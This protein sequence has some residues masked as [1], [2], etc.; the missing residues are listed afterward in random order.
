MKIKIHELE[1][2]LMHL[3]RAAEPY[4]RK[5]A[6]LINGLTGIGKT[7]TVERVAKK[8]DLNLI[9]IRL[10]TESPENIGGLPKV[11]NDY[12]IKVLH[13]KFKIMTLP[14]EPT[15]EEYRK[16]KP[17]LIFFDEA[18]RSSVWV[19]N[20]IMSLIYE[21][22]I[23]NRKLHPKS[24]VVLAINTGEKYQV[25]ELDPAL[26]E[27]CA[28]L[29]IHEV[30][31]QYPAGMVEHFRMLFP[32]TAHLILGNEALLKIMYGRKKRITEEGKE[33]PEEVSP[34]EPLEERIEEIMP[35]RFTLRRL[36]F[37]AMI[38]SYV[39]K[40][41]ISLDEKKSLLNKLLPTVVHPDLVPAM[42][43]TVP[44]FEVVKKIINREEV[45][46][47]EKELHA[48]IPVLAAYPYKD[49]YEA[50]RVVDYLDERLGPAFRDVFGTY[51]NLLGLYHGGGFVH[52]LTY[53]SDKITKKLIEL[54]EKLKRKEREKAIGSFAEVY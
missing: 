45:K 20:A 49:E 33:A 37:A 2:Y 9:D 43:G 23:E 10:A 46:L 32:D 51:M 25:E 26:I 18:N 53:I 31:D 11:Q 48:L 44:F 42:I 34:A 47:T 28:I 52:R 39:V 40:Q 21:R 14:E 35:K 24:M 1:E 19:R 13:E 41:E 17:C 4:E 50:A 22:R 29:N 27:R 7:A 3:Y 38:M 15:E 36:E 5:Y 30:V 54:E 8:L 12:F 16:A 6:I